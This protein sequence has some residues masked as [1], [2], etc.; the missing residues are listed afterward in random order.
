MPPCK[1]P[2]LPC[3]ALHAMNNSLVTGL[4]LHWTWQVPLVMLAC[5]TV[6]L[7]VLAPFARERAPQPE[8]VSVRRNRW[9]QPRTS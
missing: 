8:P 9:P 5:M 7:L 6:A 2:L 1:P 4:Q 3:V